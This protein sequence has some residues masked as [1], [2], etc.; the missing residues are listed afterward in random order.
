MSE[1]S[2]QSDHAMTFAERLLEVME[3][4]N[5]TKEELALKSELC[6]ASIFSYTS[7]RR[8]PRISSRMKLAR[9]LDIS[10]FELRV[11]HGKEPVHR[12]VGKH[13]LPPPPRR[14][15]IRSSIE[16]RIERGKAILTIKDQEMPISMAMEIVG[17][18]NALTEKE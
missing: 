7:G 11:M 16:L 5:I 13:L 15:T 4:K 14:E 9:A 6:L 1:H 3:Q 12:P 10:A 2:E 8:L 17:M 18:F